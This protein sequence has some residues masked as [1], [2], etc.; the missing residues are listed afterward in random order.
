[1]AAVVFW[2]FSLW[3]AGNTQEAYD[4]KNAYVLELIN[5]SKNPSTTLVK[6]LLGAHM[7][8]LACTSAIIDAVVFI[9]VRII[10]AF[11]SSIVFGIDIVVCRR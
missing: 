8:L 9:A 7:N 1:M 10:I 11:R 3:M 4:M 6:Y 2:N 5:D